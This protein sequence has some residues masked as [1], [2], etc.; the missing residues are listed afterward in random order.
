MGQNLISLIGAKARRRTYDDAGLCRRR[1]KERSLTNTTSRFQNRRARRRHLLNSQIDKGIGMQLNMND[2]FVSQ[3][4]ARVFYT[5][6]VCFVCSL[7]VTECHGEEKEVRTFYVDSM[8]GQ[9]TNNGFSDKHAF[10]TLERISSVKFR[11]GDHV[12][13][14]R[15]CTFSG[16]LILKSVS[17]SEEQ[18]VVIRAYGESAGKPIIDAQGYHSG[19]HI[20]GSQHIQISDIEVTNDGG[21]SL[22]K[23]ARLER[24]GVFVAAYPKTSHILLTNL[25]IHHIFAEEST[26]SSGVNPTSNFGRGIYVAI[27]EEGHETHADS[28]SGA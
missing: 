19:I 4:A 8:A 3:S 16:K 6:F 18:P 24:H 1:T 23:R 22:E 2:L 10:K 15:G 17:G 26:P 21:K 5:V 11:P 25:D 13:L 20:V 27:S 9:D 12:L 28:F 7:L 14:K